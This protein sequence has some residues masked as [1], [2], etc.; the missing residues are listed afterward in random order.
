MPGLLLLGQSDGG[1]A[2]EFK[3]ELLVMRC[4]TSPVSEWEMEIG[5]LPDPRVATEVLPGKTN[6]SVRPLCTYNYIRNMYNITFIMAHYILILLDVSVVHGWVY[7]GVS[8]GYGM[9]GI[10]SQFSN[11]P[12]S[13]SASFS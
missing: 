3:R 7:C 13:W 6:V 1:E 10:G 8:S 2:R 4:P 12:D 9:Y 11:C 5:M